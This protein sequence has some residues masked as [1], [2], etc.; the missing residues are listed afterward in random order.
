MRELRI[1]HARTASPY[2]GILLQCTQFSLPRNTR[3]PAASIACL[4][5]SEKVDA[6]A[7]RAT[8]LSIALESDSLDARQTKT[9]KL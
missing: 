3:N 6:L 7:L 5:A 8:A 9:R 4:L 1:C 2:K